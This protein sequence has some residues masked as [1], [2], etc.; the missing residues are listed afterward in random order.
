MSDFP[1]VNLAG[2]SDVAIVLIN[3]V[4]HAVEGVAK[5]RQIIRV[6]KA[7]AEAEM[8]RS[9]AKIEINER[10]Y[11]AARRLLN[12][13]TQN[14]QNMEEILRGAI[15]HLNEGAKPKEMEKD[16]ISNFFGQ[17]RSVSDEQ[18]RELWSRL[19]AGEANY[20]GSFSRRTVN[21]LANLERSDAQNFLK[22]Q[23]FVCT[24]ESKT[25]R[26]ELPVI[27]DS[28]FTDDTS[29]YDNN[30]LTEKV[31]DDLEA[32]DLI[33]RLTTVGNWDI[34]DSTYYFTLH[35]DVSTEVK[36]KYAPSGETVSIENYVE[37]VPLGVVAFTAFG[38]QLRRLCDSPTPV[39]GFVQFVGA[40]L[41]KISLEKA[42]EGDIL[43][44]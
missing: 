12:E 17:C 33:S 10:E 39:E 35:K 42:R 11:R 19:L 13:E 32:V 14:Q 41:Q 30:G 25:K 27:Y 38:Q 9:E 2:F 31:L 37:A 6:A 4:S 5:P 21:L 44:F 3:R 16:W 36:I 18:M 26:M 1:L 8:I 28:K 23:R 7:E 43:L 34:Y 29:I 24:A 40:T 15:P 22:L 20:P